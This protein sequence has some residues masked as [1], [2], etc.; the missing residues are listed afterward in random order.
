MI[1]MRHIQEPEKQENKEFPGRPWWKR[2]QEGGQMPFH[3]PFH[4]PFGH[5]FNP[6]NFN[7]QCPVMP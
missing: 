3:P 5:P 6:A 7:G 4:P 1:K 2:H